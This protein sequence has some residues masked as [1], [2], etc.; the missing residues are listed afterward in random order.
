MLHPCTCLARRTFRTTVAD[1]VRSVFREKPINPSLRPFRK[2]TAQVASI[3]AATEALS[4][5]DAL[6]LRRLAHG[7]SVVGSVVRDQSI[8][9]AAVH[10]AA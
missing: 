1:S 9:C 7:T 3:L 6:V 4:A 10:C 2:A 8:D 5:A